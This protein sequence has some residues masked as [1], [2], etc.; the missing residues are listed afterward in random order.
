RNSLGYEE[1]VM[2]T[3]TILQALGVGRQ[4]YAMEVGAAGQRTPK[5][6][7]H[8]PIRALTL[9]QQ[10]S[11]RVRVGERTV[12]I[13]PANLTEE[14]RSAL[15]V[16]STSKKVRVKSEQ[17]STEQWVAALAEQRGITRARLP[18]TLRIDRKGLENDIQR[19][20]AVEEAK[21]KSANR[22]ITAEEA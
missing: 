4:G 10:E 16:T 12:K 7:A 11:A 2:W 13:D 3:A 19:G 21:G 6:W 18:K 14:Q 17:L 5:K 9:E 22:L 1:Y 8:V 20:K 15:S